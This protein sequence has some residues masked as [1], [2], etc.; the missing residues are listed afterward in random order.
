[1]GLGPVEYK[2][3]KIKKDKLD[4]FYK[5]KCHEAYWIYIILM[6]PIWLGNGFIEL[7]LTASTCKNN[8]KAY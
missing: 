2:K 6:E 5:K 1:L 4:L 7:N 8:Q 3:N